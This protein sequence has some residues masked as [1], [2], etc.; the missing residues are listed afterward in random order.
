[1][2]NS[3]SLKSW[4]KHPPY[5]FQAH[6]NP[7][8]IRSDRSSSL[9]SSSPALLSARKK[10]SAWLSKV[11]W[12]WLRRAV[13]VVR[14]VDRG[15]RFW[16]SRPKTDGTAPRFSL[17]RCFRPAPSLKSSGRKRSSQTPLYLQLSSRSFG[18]LTASNHFLLVLSSFEKQYTCLLD[19][20]EESFSL[21]FFPWHHTQTYKRMQHTS[22][23]CFK[24]AVSYKTS[25]MCTHFTFT[26]YSYIQRSTYL[27]YS[28]HSTLKSKKH[29]F[30]FIF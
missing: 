15:F 28:L 29:F 18:L 1:M 10:A 16:A 3:S 22:W 11:C 5:L 23:P 17:R 7:D 12:S 2:N 27:Q 8:G 4:S 24:S 21:Y 26:V 19:K 9:S 6:L 20:F 30:I 25:Q 13:G 14:N